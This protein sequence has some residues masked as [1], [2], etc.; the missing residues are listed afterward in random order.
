MLEISR[1][2]AIEALLLC[3][4]LNLSLEDRGNELIGLGFNYF[5]EE[6]K[7]WDSKKVLSLKS[8]KRLKGKHAGYKYVTNKY[9]EIKILELY[10]V[11]VAVI[12]DVRT[13]GARCPCCGYLI[14]SKLEPWSIC[15][16]CKWEYD[17]DDEDKYS[18]ANRA[19]L[20]EYREEFERRKMENENDPLYVMYQK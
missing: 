8:T 4:L 11:H 19:T 5:D 10:K 1:K 2:D 14:A 15:P 18:P 3:D 13:D 17:A 6:K 12:G 20:K 7:E 16:V 9:L